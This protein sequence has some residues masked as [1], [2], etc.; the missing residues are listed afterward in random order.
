MGLTDRQVARLKVS[1]DYH[2]RY[3]D[4]F[5]DIGLSIRVNKVTNS[6]RWVVQYTLN[7]KRKMMM[8]GKYPTMSLA[9]A[10]QERDRI[11]KMALEG[12]DPKIV[13]EMQKAEVVGAT[14][15][16]IEHI[17]NSV[18]KERIKTHLAR[19][20][21]TKSE[22]PELSTYNMYLKEIWKG[23][24]LTNNGPLLR[25][26]NN[27]LQSFLGVKNIGLI[28]NG[29]MALQLAIKALNIKGDV[30]TTPF[31]YVATTNSILWENCNP[32][33]VDIDES[34]LCINP[35]LIESRITKDTSAIIAT[36]V[37]GNPCD[38]KA[39]EKIAKKNKLKVLYDA[40]HA[41][42]TKI[43]G[44]SI[45]NFGDASILS[46]HATKLF[47]TVEGGAVVCKNKKLLNKINTMKAFGH[48][49]EEKYLM[50]GIN[51]KMSELHAAMGLCNL[52]NVENCI[53]NRQ[54]KSLLYDNLQASLIRDGHIRKQIISSSVTNNYSYYP[55]IFKTKKSMLSAKK[56]LELNNI[57]PRRYFY[58]SL[59]KLK[60]L[61]RFDECKIS[62]DISQK[63]LSLPLFEDLKEAEIRKIVQIISKSILSS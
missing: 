6:K 28:A 42:H 24:Q 41:F 15:E 18:T 55:I 12:R 63:V 4:F 14:L 1:P 57:F 21:V 31:S 20:D 39:I 38:V 16:T 26:L 25:K 29:C 54:K 33:F 34:T 51:G 52:D 61:S 5:D 10:R 17:Y 37:Y 56:A 43:D 23:N 8:L 53:R 22:L 58:P 2:F 47:H 50:V 27:E 44:K 19:I 32:I 59:N 35:E 48:M 40:A 7:K 60:F 9:D 46:F 62:E 3:K 36:H 49:G 13:R 11:K 30:I 45:L